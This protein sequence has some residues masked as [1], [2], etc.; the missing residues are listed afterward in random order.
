MF[1]DFFAEKYDERRKALKWWYWRALLGLLGFTVLNVIILPFAKWLDPLE[2]RSLGAV[3][4]HFFSITFHENWL[5]PLTSGFKWFQLYLFSEPRHYVWSSFFA[6][7]I[8]LI[9]LFSLFMYELWLF[10]WNPYTMA[11]QTFG[12]THVARS[13]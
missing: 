8:P 13:Y 5:F 6:W 4:G 9:P 3:Y 2:T 12:S 7:K 10:V 1:F 11:D